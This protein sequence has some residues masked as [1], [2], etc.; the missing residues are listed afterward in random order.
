MLASL[1]Y[2]LYVAW[3]SIRRATVWRFQA[4]CLDRRIDK[5]DKELDVLLAKCH[6][7]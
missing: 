6:K 2:H 5:L 7:S 4:W 1:D 3:C